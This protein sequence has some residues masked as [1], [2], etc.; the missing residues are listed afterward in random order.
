MDSKKNY[1]FISCPTDSDLF[2]LICDLHPTHYVFP[3]IDV[4]SIFD[5][6]PSTY[7]RLDDIQSFN[8]DFLVCHKN[9]LN[10]IAAYL[11]DTKNADFI[12]RLTDKILD[13]EYI[14]VTSLAK[15][16]LIKPEIIRPSRMNDN[17][18]DVPF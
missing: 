10:P 13:N 11:K 12:I 7:D 3:N 17:E 8:I 14:A 9:T 16:G 15:M 6:E 4:W 1:G 5:I 18:A 2:R